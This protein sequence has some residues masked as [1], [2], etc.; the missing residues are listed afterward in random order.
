M[1]E[2]V[3]LEWIGAMLRELQAEQRSIHAETRLIRNESQLIHN[4]LN[5]AITLLM[6]RIGNFE[7]RGDV[8]LD[9]QRQEIVGRLEQLAAEI[10]HLGRR[11]G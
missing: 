8:R 10:S 7:A 1:S 2:T 6:Q 9:Q 3:S 11:P 4:A 5:E